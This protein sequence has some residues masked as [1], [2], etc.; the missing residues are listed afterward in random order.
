MIKGCN[1]AT[2]VRQ[3]ANFKGPSPTPRSAPKDLGDHGSEQRAL[4][5]TTAQKEPERRE[6]R[7]R[8]LPRRRPDPHSPGQRRWA[9]K[10]KAPPHSP[11][12]PAAKATWN[13]WPLSHCPEPHCRRPPR[14]RP[15]QPT[16]SAHRL[17]KV[18]PP[19]ADFRP[20]LPTGVSPL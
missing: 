9:L 8:L 3:K 2:Y 11:L 6:R 14:P 16:S 19:A 7:R 1:V 20:R 4:R 10:S 13:L 15:T 12:P 5:L 18:P 17:L